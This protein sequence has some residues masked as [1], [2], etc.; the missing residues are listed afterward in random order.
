M[1][2]YF[3]VSGTTKQQHFAH[4]WTFRQRI[5]RNLFQMNHFTTSFSL[6][7]SNQHRT[8][9]ILNT[10]PQRFGRESRENDAKKG[11]REFQGI[12]GRENL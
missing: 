9:G 12:A 3:N 1:H 6:I 4:G 5:I 7:S 10:I 8:R 2:R 11:V